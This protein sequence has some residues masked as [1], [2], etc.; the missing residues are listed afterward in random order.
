MAFWN[1]VSARRQMLVQLFGKGL[2]TEEP[3]K[4][5]IDELTDCL[6]VS[7]DDYPVIRTRN[8]RVWQDV[9]SL[10]TPRGLGS[11][12][13]SQMH[14]LADASWVYRTLASTAWTPI[15]NYV[16]TTNTVQASF[17]EFHTYALTTDNTTGSRL[18]YTIGA[19][20]NS[21]NY[22]NGYW[23]E[24]S[25]FGLF[26]TSY[27]E[28]SSGSTYTNYP[29]QSN[30]MA[31]HRYRVYGMDH[32][33][34]TLRFSEL[35]NPLWYKAENYLD[36][37]EMKGSAQAMCAFSDHIIVWG[38][39]SMHELY[40]ESNFNFELVNVSN[41]IGCVGPYAWTECDS[42]LYWVDYNGIYMYTGGK[43]NLIGV[44]A[45]KYFNGINW[46]VRKLI[47]CGS[48]KEKLYINIPY[49]T[50]YNNK[51]IV[52]DTRGILEGRDLVTIEDGNIQS[53]CS[54]ADKLYALHN[55]GRIWDMRS[56]Q[57]TGKDNSTAISWSFETK[58][59]TDEGLN[60]KSAVREVWIEH[61]GSASTEM[62]VKYTT[63]SHSTTYSAFM[64]T[65][66]FTHTSDIRV[67]RKICAYNQLQ[68]IRYVKWQFKGTGH[69]KILGL[70]AELMTYGNQD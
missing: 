24:D 28:P 1:N 69:K 44:K 30:I 62:T 33:L 9:D 49:G 12:G 3:T 10:T 23:S 36:I 53:F 48:Y 43:P 31:V 42:R 20:I 63:N 15:A 41:T 19:F 67:D 26:T 13:T 21:S 52:I 14:A 4:I 57:K 46:D 60:V 6:N 32:D 47:A 25:T 51:I 59:M 11:R 45:R 56:T 65:A 50:T 39:H 17:H 27:A 58:P 37:T 7:C 54:I 70:H 40:G 61:Q 8:D 34:R 66:D 38:E 35:G 29:P 16:G 22:Q 18:T 68:G 55:D 2:N 5:N 64:T